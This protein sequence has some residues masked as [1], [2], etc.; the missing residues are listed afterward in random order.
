M[1][2]STSKDLQD[3]VKRE[4]DN[5]QKL[6]AQKQEAEEILNGLDEEKAKL[7]KQLNA[8]R[9]QCIE[10][11][12]LVGHRSSTFVNIFFSHLHWSK[13]ST[14]LIW[15]EHRGC[16]SVSILWDEQKGDDD[17]DLFSNLDCTKLNWREVATDPAL[18]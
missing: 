15:K 3:E 14:H 1:C 16:R 5:L 12:D 10:E 8:I 2:Y 13:S 11:A 4:N 18:V 7:E 6:L 9:Q 17:K